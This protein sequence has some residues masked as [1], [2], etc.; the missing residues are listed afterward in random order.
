MSQAIPSTYRSSR[1]DVR[2]LDVPHAAAAGVELQRIAFDFDIARESS[3]FEFLADDERARAARFLRPEDAVRYSTTRAVLRE[4]IAACLDMRPSH[5]RFRYDDA[6]RPSIADSPAGFDFN[7]S[8]SGGFALIAL[9]HGRRVGVDIESK[10]A[11]LDWRS[12][13]QAVFAPSE[14]ACVEALPEA[15]RL[16]AF[17][18]V[19]TAKESLLKAIG[20]GIAGG[21]DRFSVLGDVSTAPRVPILDASDSPSLGVHAFDACWCD[22]PAGYAACVAWSKSSNALNASNAPADR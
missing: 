1:F 13:A 6:G 10:R 12:L 14:H 17:F 15:A 21:L 19:W 20:V 9:S 16:D 4:S 5:V 2:V 8:H 18:A 11:A 3:V 7:V 22:A